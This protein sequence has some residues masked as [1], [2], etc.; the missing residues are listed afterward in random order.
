MNFLIDNLF[1]YWAFGFGVLG[2][3]VLGV[4]V[5]TLAFYPEITEDNSILKQGFPLSLVF[6]DE[7]LRMVQYS[8]N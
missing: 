6:Q 2:V 4:G 8:V 5:L 3:D 7:L 1:L